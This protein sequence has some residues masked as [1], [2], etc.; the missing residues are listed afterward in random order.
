[1]QAHIDPRAHV[2]VFVFSA[3]MSIQLEEVGCVVPV[4]LAEA[5]GAA[6]CL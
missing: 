6:F 4:R 5:D 1:M 3:A 2:H